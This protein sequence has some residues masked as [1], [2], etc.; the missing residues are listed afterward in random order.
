MIDDESKSSHGEA[1]DHHDPLVQ[2]ATTWLRRPEPVRSEWRDALLARVSSPPRRRA[3]IGKWIPVG[4]A[5]ALC[6]AI[7]VE[8]FA[9]RHNGDRVRFSVSAP[10]AKRV[11]LVGDFD[12]WDPSAVP[13]RRGSTDLWIVDLELPPGRHVFAFSID[14]GLHADSAAPRAVEDDFGVPSSV[15]VVPGRGGD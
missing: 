1:T 7:G 9:T 2:R 12:D 13:M 15:I 6:A 4:I 8:R 5:A 10:S 11:S 3:S 14:G